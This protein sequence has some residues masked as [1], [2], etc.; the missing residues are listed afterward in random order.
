MRFYIPLFFPVEKHPNM[1]HVLTLE[2][3]R[4]LYR[5]NISPKAQ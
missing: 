1:K 3:E 2:I 4:L 5:T